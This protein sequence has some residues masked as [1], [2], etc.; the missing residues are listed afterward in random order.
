[1]TRHLTAIAESVTH[2]DEC[3]LSSCLRRLF[4]SKTEDAT[5]FSYSISNSL[6]GLKEALGALNQ[7]HPVECSFQ[8][9]ESLRLTLPDVAF[10][11]AVVYKNHQ[12]VLLAWFQMFTLTSRNFNPE[13]NKGFVKRILRFFIDLKGVRVLIAGNALRNNTP[14]LCFDSNVINHHEAAEILVS[15]AEKIG[16]D[17]NVAGLV[18]KDFSFTPTQQKWLAGM[19][20]E[21]PWE[22]LEM[23]L[24][25]HPA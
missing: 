17:E 24:D 13:K 10:R 20:F 7:D 19:G 9:L 5:D 8:Y 16:A 11:Y 12:P 23:I 18:I 25:I 15:V 21:K 1:M 22:D 2:F 14:C 4:R 3:L 6:S